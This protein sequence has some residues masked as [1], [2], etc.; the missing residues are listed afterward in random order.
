MKILAR[1]GWSLAV[2]LS[3]VV[4]YTSLQYLRP[5][6]V[7]PDFIMQNLMAAWLPLHAGFAVVALLIGPAQFAPVVRKRWPKLHRWMGR[8]YIVSALISGVAGLVLAAGTAAGPVA[9]AG[10]TGLGVLSLVCAVQAW[11]LAMA[12]RFDEHRR[13]VVRSYALML[14]GVTLRLWLPLSM[15]LQLDLMTSYRVISFLC[16]V[17]NLL[18]A[19]L[20]LARRR[21]TALRSGAFAASA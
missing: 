10:F 20:Y 11:R 4:A 17:P 5:G 15:V 16:W 21:R 14:A 6:H 2:L 9:L 3:L 1:T 18:V 12:R 8:A 13:W 19:E 7:G